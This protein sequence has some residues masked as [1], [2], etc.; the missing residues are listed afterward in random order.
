MSNKYAATAAKCYQQA[1]QAH[2]DKVA[3][4]I[5]SWKGWG[6]YYHQRLTQ[7]YQFLVAQGQRV[8]EL[9]CGRGD[10]LAAL[11]PQVGVGVDFSLEMVE[12]A[13]RRHPNLCFIHTD[14]H[15]LPL[16]E[17]FDVIIL[18]DLVNDLWDV[19]EV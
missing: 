1:R 19:Q 3:C 11:K 15:E 2:W 9:G 12:R 14:A 5:D 16:K 8:L 17:E 4:T 7:I 18:S 6:G 10:L 13:R